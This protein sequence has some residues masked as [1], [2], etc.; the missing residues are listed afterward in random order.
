MK[1][2]AD[3]PSGPEPDFL[4]PSSRGSSFFFAIIFFAIIWFL[5]LFF[6]VKTS[7][8]GYSLWASL[9]QPGIILLFALTW[10]TNIQFNLQISFSSSESRA[11][12]PAWCLS[13]P[14]VIGI[15]INYYYVFPCTQSSQKCPDFWCW[16]FEWCCFG[17]WRG[18]DHLWAAMPMRVGRNAHKMAHSRGFICWH[19]HTH[20][21]TVIHTHTLTDTHTY[22]EPREFYDGDTIRWSMHASGHVVTTFEL[23]KSALTHM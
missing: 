8:G 2:G 22:I 9:Y 7:D 1:C 17:F 5:I 13:T 19:T 6:Q 21:H 4:R 23:S 3:G 11:T 16:D 10:R 20:T 14:N 18:G 12:S 15:T